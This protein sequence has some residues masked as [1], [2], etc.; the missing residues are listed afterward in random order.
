[1]LV[2]E[3]ECSDSYSPPSYVEHLHSLP[4]VDFH[5]DSSQNATFEPKEGSYWEVCTR[6]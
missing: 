3:L 1:M 4:R 6:R 5:F 2:M